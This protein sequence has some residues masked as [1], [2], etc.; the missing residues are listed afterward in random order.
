MKVAVLTTSY[1]RYEG[2]AAGTF[3]AGGVQ[4]LR[5]RGVEVEVVSPASFRHFGIAY[6]HGVVGNLRRDPWR[7]L[8]LPAMLASFAR[9]ARRAAR[10]ADLVHAHWLGAG[11]VAR[12]TGKPFVLQLWGTDVELARRFRLPARTV[13]RAARSAICASRALAQDARELGAR[14]VRVI[15]SGVDVPARV[16]EPTDPPEVLFV[17][18]LSAEKGILD[19]VQAAEGMPLVVAGDGPLRAQVPGAL[20]FVPHHELGPLYERAA[21]V[22]VPSHREGFG[23]VALE[24]MAHGR[25][26]VAS[27]VGGLLDIVVDGETGLLVPPGDVTALRAALERLLGD[28]DLRRRLGEAGRERAREHFAWPAVTDA[29]IAAYEDALAG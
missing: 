1:P 13:V 28:A 5:E 3:V 14:E 26:V 21:V 9:A 4:A 12:A 7:G 19:L 11:I 27:A 16:G 6:G 10:D 22:A 25:P 23:V 8:L 18:R 2:D 29:T 15:P 17:G 20:G 24:A